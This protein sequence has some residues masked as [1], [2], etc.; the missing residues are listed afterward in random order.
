MQVEDTT[1][2]TCSWCPKIVK[3]SNLSYYNLKIHRD[4]SNCKGTIRAACAGRTQA[5]ADGAKLP[6]TAAQADT[7]NKTESMNKPGTTIA[8]YMTK[9]RFDN[10]TFN[11]LIVFWL[12]RHSLPWLRVKDETLHIVFDYLQP[13]TYLH[14]RTWAATTAHSLYLSLQR[15]VLEGIQ[16]C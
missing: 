1:S 7:Q 15:G 2:Y 6:L 5:I 10:N 14:S 4:G 13:S 3:A 11:K 9:G 8:S 12:L 16:V